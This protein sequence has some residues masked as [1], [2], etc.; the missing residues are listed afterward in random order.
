MGGIEMQDDYSSLWTKM[1]VNKRKIT[2]QY[3][4]TIQH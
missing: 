1:K 3:Y 2:I 4:I